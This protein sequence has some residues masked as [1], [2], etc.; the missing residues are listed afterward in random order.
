MRLRVHGF[1]LHMRTWCAVALVALACAL[2]GCN[3]HGAGTVEPREYRADVVSILESGD[4]TIEQV[5]GGEPLFTEEEVAHAEE[6]LG[7]ERYSEL[8]ALGRCGVAEACLG[9]ENMPGPHE[10]RG[11]ISD[12][13]PSGWQSARYRFVEGESLYNRSHL[14]AWSLS[15]ENANEGNLVTGTR[16]MNA[17]SMLG[18]ENQVARYIDRTG[19]HVLYRVTPLFEGDELVCRAVQM[20][21]RSIEDDGVGVSFDVLCRNVQPGVEIDYATGDN[22]LAQPDTAEN[23][24]GGQDEEAARS[25][26]LNTSSRKFHLPACSGAAA[27]DASNR[28]DVTATR[29]ELIA[30]GYQPCGSCNP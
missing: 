18:Y 7:F 15:S 25:Y 20:E 4:N 1:V 27:M 13:H 30:E 26:V 8:D 29:S 17:E 3:V 14:I 28:R 10:E 16:Y 2:S 6:N 21:A 22:W 9:P 5:N 11:D 19:N 23:A 24:D 12:I